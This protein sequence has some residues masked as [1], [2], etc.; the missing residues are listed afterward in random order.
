MNIPDLRPVPPR[1]TRI[2]T[3]ISL[4]CCI[5]CLASAVFAS[6]VL[7]D[8]FCMFA[9]VLFAVGTVYL[10]IALRSQRQDK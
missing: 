5:L 3:I 4:V 2:V 10:A 7:R 6:I 8:A 9:T 1:L